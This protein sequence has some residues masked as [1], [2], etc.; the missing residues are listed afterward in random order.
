MVTSCSRAVACKSS[1]SLSTKRLAKI[2]AQPTIT[3]RAIEWLEERAAEPDK[4]FFLYMP[5]LG[6]HTPIVPSYPYVGR[7]DA[8]P[9]GDWVHQMDSILER[10]VGTLEAKGL[11]EN[12]IVIFSSDNGSPARSGI[13]NFGMTHSV[14]QLYSHVPNAPWRGLKADAWEAGHRV[15]LVVRWDGRVK[16][17]STND[18]TVV[19]TD[20]F[21]TV[22][23]LV[24]AEMPANSGEDSFSMASLL[25]KER[26]GSYAREQ[27]IHHSHRGLFAIRKG[28]WKLIL[29]MGS[30][31]FSQPRA[32]ILQPGEEGPMQL[33]LLSEDPGERRNLASQYPER[34]QAL[35]D[36]LMRLIEAGRSR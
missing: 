22:A 19:L 30:G 12:T 23:E 33:Y 2:A 24:G 18:A 27:A 10:V 13:G 9:Y 35:L 4:P 11:M 8:G 34:K 3:A 32:K 6:P 16:A 20:V 28:D 21:A 25:L 31:G 1:G 14:T 15:P 29:G 26:A 5:L 36:E 17:G 7:S